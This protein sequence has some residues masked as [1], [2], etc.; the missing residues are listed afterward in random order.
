M[1]WILHVALKINIVINDFQNLGH[2]S[3]E[4]MLII[5]LNQKL[6]R[7]LKTITTGIRL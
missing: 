3:N 4:L 6:A 2:D 5:Y 7:S 1:D